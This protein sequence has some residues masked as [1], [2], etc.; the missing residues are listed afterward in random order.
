MSD[1]QFNLPASF[2]KAHDLSSH[3]A[4][5]AGGPIFTGTASGLHSANKAHDYYLANGFQ[6][7]RK[8][9]ID[10][11]PNPWKRLLRASRLF[12]NHKYQTI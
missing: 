7:S 10:A 1:Q 3:A 9:A 12:T 11:S 2:G 8:P 4:P 6:L 5:D